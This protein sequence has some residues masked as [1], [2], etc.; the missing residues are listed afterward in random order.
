VHRL[1]GLHVPPRDPSALGAALAALLADPARRAE[2]G[3]AGRRRAVRRFGWDRI[4]AATAAVY[5]QAAAETQARH[6]ARGRR[7]V[8]A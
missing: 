3:L 7:G 4:A 8:R 5:E 1:T 6:R 2:L